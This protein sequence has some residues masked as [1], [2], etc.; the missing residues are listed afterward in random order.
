MTQKTKQTNKQQNKVRTKHGKLDKGQLNKLKQALNTLMLEQNIEETIQQDP[1]QFAHRY[2][3]PL[4]QELAAIFASMLAFGRVS[5]FLPVI[6]QWMSLCDERGG[7][8]ACVDNFSPADFDAFNALSYRWNKSPDFV[9]V[10]LTFQRLF[11]QE[12]SVK[13]WIESLYQAEDV[14]LNDTLSRAMTTLTAC[15]I[16]AGT[17]TGLSIETVSDLPDGFKRFF[18]SPAKGSACK[19]WQMLMRWMVRKTAPDLGLWELPPSKLTIPLDVH[20]HSISQMIGLTKLKSA[21]LKAAREITGH[22]RAIAPDDPI[23]YDFALAHL[24]I[25]GQCQKAYNLEICPSCP[26]HDLCIHTKGTQAN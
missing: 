26:L 2:T 5:L 24:G 12:A 17:L 20:V 25:S 13:S 8:R 6:K 14:D 19:R 15:A 9:L 23:Q 1:I 4:D 3:D 21:N 11:T 16:Y 7:P 22:L 10:M 18:S